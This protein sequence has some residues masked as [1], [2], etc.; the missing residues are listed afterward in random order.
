MKIKEITEEKITFDN[1][2]TITYGHERDCCEYNYAD[3]KQVRNEDIFDDLFDHDFPEKLQ[4]QPVKNFGFRFGSPL[5]WI[6]VPCYSEQNGCYSTHLSIITKFP[7]CQYVLH[8]EEEVQEV[9][10]D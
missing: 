3:F 6:P 5:L 10:F 7:D 9:L 8:L 1:G 2:T 4:V